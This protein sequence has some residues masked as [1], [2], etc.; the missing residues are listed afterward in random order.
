[1][2]TA[3]TYQNEQFNRHAPNAMRKQKFFGDECFGSYAFLFDLQSVEDLSCWVCTCLALCPTWESI[4][5][6]L[7]SDSAGLHLTTLVNDQALHAL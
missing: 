6:L 1:M 5:P 3:I 2:E 7:H 4:L